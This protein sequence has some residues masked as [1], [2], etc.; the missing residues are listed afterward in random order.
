MTKNRYAFLFDLSPTDY[1]GWARGLKK[2]GYATNPHYAQLLIKII[3]DY[4][5][6]DLDTQKYRPAPSFVTTPKVR[7]D[8]LSHKQVAEALSEDVVSEPEMSDEF[9]VTSGGRRQVLMNN[10]VNYI[11]V[12]KGDTFESLTDELGL[13]RGELPKYNELDRHDTLRAGQ[14]LYLQ[15]KRHQAAPGRKVH[16]VKE[17][18]TM[19]S[20]S[21]KYAIR[22][23]Y[24]YEMNGMK[25]GE[26]PQPGQE[27]KLRK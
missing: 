13:V 19:Y 14:I 1:K 8:S 27:I 20:I 6:Y 5:L 22:L 15:P 7:Q 2:A 25:P 23:K 11:I 4:H 21:Q 3:E 16:I 12:R 26:E 10:R 9:V 17:G 18:E 24:L